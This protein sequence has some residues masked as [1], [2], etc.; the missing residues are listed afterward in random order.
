MCRA[1][2]GMLFGMGLVNLCEHVRARFLVV[3]SKKRAGKEIELI[4]SLVWSNRIDVLAQ[5]CQDG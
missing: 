4:S 2:E 1:M 3:A 5:P